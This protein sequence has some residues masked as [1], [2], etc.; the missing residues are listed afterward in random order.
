[1]RKKMPSSLSPSILAASR[2]SCGNDRDACRN[3]STRNGV[4]IAGRITAAVV[5]IILKFANIW[6][7]GIMVAANGIMIAS[8][9]KPIRRSLPGEWKTSN[10]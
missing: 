6:N 10:P 9:R 1:M 4:A 7:N 3:S 2:I 8:S 5:L